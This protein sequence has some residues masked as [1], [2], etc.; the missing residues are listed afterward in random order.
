[1]FAR[2]MLLRFCTML[3]V[4]ALFALPV[5]AFAQDAA[6]IAIGQNAVSELTANTPTAIY[7]LTSTGGESALVQVLAVSPNFIPAFRILNPAGVEILAAPNAEAQASLIASASFLAAGDYTIE[8]SGVNGTLGQFVLSLQTGAPLP[9]PVELTADQPVS[10]TLSSQMP[11]AIYHFS[12][13][14]TD[15]LVLTVLTD[16]PDAGILIS[17]YDETAA[18][19]IAASDASLSGIAIRLPATE[20]GY[21]LEIRA[22]GA[23]ATAYTLCLGV[24]ATSL[25]TSAAAQPTTVPTSEA[26]ATT[27]TVAVASGGSVNIRSGPGTQ[28]TAIGTLFAG[29]SLPVLGQ[30]A[31]GAWLQVSLTNGTA[32]WV[33]ASVTQLAG[34]CAAL[35]VVAAPVNAPL[36][37]TLPPPP[38]PTNP[39]PPTTSGGTAP[40]AM[41]T[42]A[43]APTAV[44]VTELLPDLS[45]TLSYAQFLEDGRVDIGY[46]WLV[47]DVT[48]PFSYSIQICIDNT[49]IFNPLNTSV[50]TSGAFAGIV[51]IIADGRRITHTATVTIDSTNDV[52]ESNES[53]NVASLV[54]Q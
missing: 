32:G 16:T 9:D 3:T 52:V 36:A 47:R 10:A 19:T 46:S 53:N 37:P 30:L 40:T 45:V 41:P 7:S 31:G 23:E 29:Q 24:C 13:P 50:S 20:T 25:L 14:P 26:S 17:L 1:M 51:D 5:I 49:C 12:T 35:P 15:P 33:A 43:P 34:D 27:C 2:R 11:L 4:F 22:S 42:S 54:F 38:A 48:N 6:P 21:R 18:K 39:P 28:F 44:P 8:I